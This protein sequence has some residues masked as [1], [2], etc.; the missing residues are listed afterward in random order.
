[1]SLKRNELTVS[2]KNANLLARIAALV[3]VASATALGG[4]LLSAPAYAAP[5]TGQ[6]S[7]QA[8]FYCYYETTERTNVHMEP[9]GS[10]V[11]ILPEG[12]VL[13]ISGGLSQ[14]VMIGANRYVEGS[15][16]SRTSTDC[17]H[18]PSS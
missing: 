10:L 13:M 14:W 5:A 12:D 3:A 1:M 7:A 16:L 2:K 8:D 4:A 18:L 11:D 17:V 9:G 15:N 6:T